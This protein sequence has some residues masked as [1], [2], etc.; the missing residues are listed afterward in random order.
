M[1]GLCRPLQQ[2]CG[3]RRNDPRGYGA[4]QLG[5]RW[6]NGPTTMTMCAYTPR[7]GAPRLLPTATATAPNGF[8]RIP[9][10]LRVLDTTAKLSE[11]IPAD[12]P[13]QLEPPPER[14]PV[15][16]VSSRVMGGSRY[17]RPRRAGLP[18]P[19]RAL[20][21][22]H[23]RPPGADD[24]QCAPVGRSRSVAAPS[25]GRLPLRRELQE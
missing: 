4:C 14:S 1:Q 23:T 21:G 7:T 9:V 10:P 19:K 15:V 8:F 20:R 13:R 3:G 24:G 22:T 11:L 16:L 12:R 17:A 5:G 25:S 6:G 2:S 18:R